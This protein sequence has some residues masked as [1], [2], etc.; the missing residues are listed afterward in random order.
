M[1]RENNGEFLF[2]DEYEARDEQ[3]FHAD[4][5]NREAEIGLSKRDS[6]EGDGGEE[7]SQSSD[8]PVF[9]NVPVIAAAGR[10][11]RRAD[12]KYRQRKMHNSAVGK[13]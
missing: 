1:A 2:S 5:F 6:Y 7:I 10:K 8:I 13:A 3:F 12:K 9:T 4:E 11:K